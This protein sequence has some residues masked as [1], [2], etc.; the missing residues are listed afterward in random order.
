MSYAADKCLDD[1]GNLN[2]ER[3]QEHRRAFEK[4]VVED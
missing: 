1:A 3:W 2:Q 4:H